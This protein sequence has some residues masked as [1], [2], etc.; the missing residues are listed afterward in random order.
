VTEKEQELSMG[1]KKDK[2]KMLVAK[3]ERKR[4]VGVWGEGKETMLKY[5]LAKGVFRMYIKLI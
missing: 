5:I 2:S 1:K 4:L 3:H